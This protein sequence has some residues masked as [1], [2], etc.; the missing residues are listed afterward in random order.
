MSNNEIENTGNSIRKRS[1]KFLIWIIHTAFFMDNSGK[2]SGINNERG[3]MSIVDWEY[4]IPLTK[5]KET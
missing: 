3:I 2:K 5:E 4:D 1:E